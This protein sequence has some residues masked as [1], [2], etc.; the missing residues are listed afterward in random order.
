MFEH[1]GMVA[2]MASRSPGLF[3]IIVFAL[4][5]SF[6]I[7]LIASLSV[8]VCLRWVTPPTSSFILQ[9]RVAVFFAGERGEKVY[10]QW[11]TWPDI[12]PNIPIAVVAA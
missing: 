11:V 5:K 12:S 3:R 6:V 1:L 7:F 8:V 4:L 9:S 10:H 2:T